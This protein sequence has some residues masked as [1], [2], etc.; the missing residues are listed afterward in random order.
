M[1]EYI[2]TLQNASNTV[3]RVFRQ[4]V[5]ERKSPKLAFEQIIEMYKGTSAETYVTEYVKICTEVMGDV[6]EPR[7]YLEEALKVTAEAW[8]VF[9]KHIGK[10]YAEEM[11]DGDWN[12]LIKDATDIGYRH[13]ST[14]VK[15]YAK[16][17]SCLC[18]EELDRH[19]RR[20]HHI[21]EDWEKG[22]AKGDIHAL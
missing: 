21:R 20:I 10:L 14:N 13:W 7:A 11:T 5:M 22:I 9:K 3:W 8:G 16:R 19:Y 17:Y 6:K 4:C 12:R 1:D 18:V 2:K 15:E